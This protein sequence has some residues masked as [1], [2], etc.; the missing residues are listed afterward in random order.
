MFSKAAA[1]KIFP[2]QLMNDWSYDTED[3]FLAE[4]FKLRIKEVPV[5]WVY[6]ST[7]KVKPIRDGIKS[8]ISLV[9]IKMND[10]KGRYGD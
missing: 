10:I 1:L 5:R 8:F 9:R 7:S 6:K 3:I 2:K 4:K